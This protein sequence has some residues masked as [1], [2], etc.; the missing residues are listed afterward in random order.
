MFQLTR[1]ADYAIRLML[2]V[3]SEPTGRLSTA[4]VA[5]RQDIPYPFLRKVAQTLVAEGLLSAER[6]ARGGLSLARAA[7]RISMLDILN[8]TERVALNDCTV[9]PANCDRRVSCAAYPVWARAQHAVEQVLAGTSL[10]ELAAGGARGRIEA[11]EN[12]VRRS[13]SKGP[14]RNAQKVQTARR[15]Q[16]GDRAR[17][18]VDTTQGTGGPHA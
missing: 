2:E 7:G 5:T 12:G 17:L 14:R 8:A 6:G 15:Q 1:K 4:A 16:A 13:H 10:A 3:A 18:A 11:Q 9:I